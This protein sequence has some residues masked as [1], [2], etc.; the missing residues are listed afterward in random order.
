MLDVGH[1]GQASGYH[2]TLF[3]A[4][5]NVPALAHTPS[6]I[7]LAALSWFSC[8]IGLSSSETMHQDEFFFL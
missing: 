1:Q 2:P 8:H 6:A 5:S 4:W 3:L 7:I